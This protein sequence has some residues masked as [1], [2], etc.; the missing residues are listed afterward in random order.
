MVIAKTKMQVLFVATFIESANL[1]ECV[2][3]IR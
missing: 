3:F 2:K 1:L